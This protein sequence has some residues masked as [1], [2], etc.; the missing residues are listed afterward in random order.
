MVSPL[1]EILETQFNLL[2]HLK[3]SVVDFENMDIRDIDWTYSRLVKQ[4]KDENKQR[5]RSKSI[6][7]KYRS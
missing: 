2:Y 6:P 5:E 7:E 1:Q 4:I 3:M